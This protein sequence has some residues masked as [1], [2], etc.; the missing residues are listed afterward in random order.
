MHLFD[1]C[2]RGGYVSG[3]PCSRASEEYA[4]RNTAEKLRVTRWQM[5]T[6][7]RPGEWQPWRRQPCAVSVT[8]AEHGA[9]SPS[10]PA[11][12]GLPPATIPHATRRQPKKR[13]RAVMQACHRP[14]PA[15]H[16][17]VFFDAADACF[18]AFFF[19]FLSI[20]SSADFHDTFG[21][22]RRHCH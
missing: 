11:S 6:E 8:P 21:F 1:V 16:A 18:F 4:A 19:F 15:R 13:C 2:S 20:F 14:I 9:A 7:G 3:F 17:A 22:A 10:P 12:V 5:S